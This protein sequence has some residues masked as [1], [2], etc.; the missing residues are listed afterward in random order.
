MITAKLQSQGKTGHADLQTQRVQCVG[1]SKVEKHCCFL[2]C[3][4]V[5]LAA[6][7]PQYD[8]GRRNRVCIGSLCC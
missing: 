3:T 5:Y 6:Y 7:L 8:F 2:A 4:T 1:P